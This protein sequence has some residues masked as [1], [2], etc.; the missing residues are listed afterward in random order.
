MFA[1]ELLPHLKG[2]E[3]VLLALG[4]LARPVLANKL[5]STLPNLVVERV[6]V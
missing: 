1:E 3:K 5:I 2:D 6:D 4:R